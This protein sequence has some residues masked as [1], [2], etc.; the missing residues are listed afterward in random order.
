MSEEQESQAVV[1]AADQLYAEPVEAFVARRGEL[2]AQVAAEH[3]KATG[4][5]V[6][7]LRKPS[8]AAWAVNLLVRREGEQIDQVLA[9]AEQLRAAAAALDGEELRALTRQRR[10]L[11]TALATTARRRAKEA[12]SRLSEPVVEQVEGM[13]TAAMLDPV[14]AQV[15]RTGRVVTA[16]S[17]TGMSELDVAGVVACPEALGHQAAPVAD[18]PV[19]RPELR[20]VEDPGAELRQAEEALEEAESRVRAAEAE[21]E[22]VQASVQELDARRLQLQGQA[23]ELRR[24]LAELDQEADDVEE[25]HEEATEALADA[26][27]VL[28]EAR[29]EAEQA[30]AEVA[31]LQD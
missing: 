31:R 24:Q 26:D 13:L 28:A 5:R 1:E 15:V 27:L 23:E 29:S 10:Q 14:A 21:Q 6:T 12:G 25:E 19:A 2:A 18:D 7:K 3:G 22:E 30:R 8:V 16:F 17:S 20:L 9:L 4:Q 11:T